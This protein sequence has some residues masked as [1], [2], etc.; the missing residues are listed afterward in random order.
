MVSTDFSLSGK[1]ALVAGDSK[2]W[3]RYAGA[4][5]AEA[6]ADVAFAA[7]NAQRLE[8][9]AEEVRRQ[10]QKALTV[11]TD[12]TD[13]SQV[14]KMTDQ[15]VAEFGRIDILVNTSDLVLA[16]PFLET[17]EAE[18]RRVLDIDRADR[19]PEHVGLDLPPQGAF[20]ASADE[21]DVVYL[22]T[23]LADEFHAVAQAERDAFHHRAHHVGP[24]VAQA[25]A[26]EHSARV[27]VGVGCPFAAEVGEEN[28]PF[29]S[30]RCR[31]GHFGQTVGPIA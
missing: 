9:A 29:G 15:V 22:H 28:Q 14:Q 10:G 12:A 25:Q 26:R 8:E 19:P 24:G 7:R 1:T 23:Q 17:S 16:K 30:R 31:C 13:A 5:L 20:R 27:G 4:A 18:W 11:P 3:S 2:Y 21:H 6:G